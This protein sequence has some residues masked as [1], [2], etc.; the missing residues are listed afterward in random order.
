LGFSA[1]ATSYSEYLQVRVRSVEH[2]W[3]FIKRSFIGSLVLMLACIPVTLI[4]ARIVTWALDQQ[5]RPVVPIFMCV[6]ASMILLILQA[7][8][9]AVCQY[10]LKPHLITVG[11]VI[12]ATLIAIAGLL[13][14]PKMGAMGAA[15]AQLIGSAAAL[16]PL[17]LLV[18][19]SLRSSKQFEHQASD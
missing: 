2:I 4:V 14:A 10:L 6:A 16:I 13:L 1:I 17:T 18:L 9:V 11:W 19:S 8:L 12:R 5:L 7:P 15:I 3:R